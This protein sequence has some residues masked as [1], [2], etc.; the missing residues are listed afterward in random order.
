MTLYNLDC[1][2]VTLCYCVTLW[3]FFTMGYVVLHMRL[4]SCILDSTLYT[5]MLS[6]DLFL[7]FWTR[8]GSQIAM[9]VVGVVV[10]L[11]KNA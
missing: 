6:V 2:P 7:V 3:L 10:T 9:T 4:C 8:K 1:P 11:S 5:P